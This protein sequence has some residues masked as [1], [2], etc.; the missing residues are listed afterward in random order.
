[1]VEDLTL[2]AGQVKFLMTRFQ[3]KDPN[4]AIDLF[5]EYLILERLDPMKA[6]YYI[7]KLMQRELKELDKKDK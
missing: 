6:K 7:M 4:K 5:L 3:I 1:M 2:T